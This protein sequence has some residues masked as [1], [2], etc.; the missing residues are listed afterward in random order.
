MVKSS[1]EKTGQLVSPGE[2]LGV[3]EEFIPDAGTYVKDGVIYS[4]IVGRALLDLS[5]RRVSV[6]RL[7]HEI[8]VPK[9]G[10]TVVG[11]VASVQSDNAMV[12]IFKIDKKELSGV[13]SGVLHVSDVAMRY[14]DSMFDVCK[15]GDV[16]RASVISEKNQTYHLSTKDR[17]LGVVYAFCSNC[18]AMLV[19]RRQDMNCPRCGNIE[20]RKTAFDYGKEL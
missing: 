18:G 2:R 9:V 5:T 19:P 14:V 3:I 4:T 15:A 16:V 20:R 6:F 10:N 12:R 1:E 11:Q 7:V 8:K 13:F 17:N